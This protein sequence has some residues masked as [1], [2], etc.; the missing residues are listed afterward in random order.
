MSNNLLVLELSLL[1]LSAH[2]PSRYPML[3]TDSLS[4][5]AESRSSFSRTPSQLAQFLFVRIVFSTPRGHGAI[6]NGRNTNAAGIASATW[7]R[8]NKST[9]ENDPR[10]AGFTLCMPVT[11][12]YTNCFYKN[13]HSFG[14]SVR[15]EHASTYVPRCRPVDVVRPAGRVPLH[16]SPSKRSRYSADRLQPRRE[17]HRMRDEAEDGRDGGREE[18]SVGDQ[19]I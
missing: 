8:R 7:N 5:R 14:R 15:V 9:Q 16:A 4:L 12:N 17:F 13:G 19:G 10:R 18:G 3:P 2:R 6:I 1:Y 11:V